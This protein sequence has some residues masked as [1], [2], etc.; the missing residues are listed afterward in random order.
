MSTSADS[1]ARIAPQLEGQA[2]ELPSWAFGNSGTRFKVFGSPG[3]ARTVEEKVADAA[4]CTASRAWPERRAHIRGT[5]STT[6]APCAATPRTS[7]SRWGPSTP[8]RSRT[9][10]TSSAP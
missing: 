4:T 5:S 9:T 1:F 2:I 3:T 7:G 8:T 6:S 10:T